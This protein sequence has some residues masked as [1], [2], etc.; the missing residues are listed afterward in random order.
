MLSF[1]NLSFV[2][3]FVLQPSVGFGSSIINKDMVDLDNE[4]NL[5]IWLYFRLM[6]LILI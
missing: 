1:I 2:V 5:G 6:G 4:T 3:I